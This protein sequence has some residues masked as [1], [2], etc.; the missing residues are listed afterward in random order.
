MRSEIPDS[1]GRIQKRERNKEFNLR[2]RNK[3]FNLRERNK[4][5]P[6]PF[7]GEGARRADEGTYSKGNKNY[8]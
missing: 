3:E 4:L 8:K 6:S 1:K 2:E 5:K 7:Q